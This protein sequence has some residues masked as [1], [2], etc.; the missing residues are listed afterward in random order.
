VSQLTFDDYTTGG[1]GNFFAHLRL[2][3]PT[4]AGDCR[5]DEFCADVGEF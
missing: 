2:N 4:C 1:E 5:C 3:I